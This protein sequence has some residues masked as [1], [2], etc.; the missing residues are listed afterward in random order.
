MGGEREA[1][2]VSITTL[3]K[4]KQSMFLLNTKS[5]KKQDQLSQTT[6]IVLRLDCFNDTA[7][8][9]G[10]GYSHIPVEFYS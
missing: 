9:S 4:E 2:N 3:N 8:S 6:V 1:E 5:Q 10:E 7:T